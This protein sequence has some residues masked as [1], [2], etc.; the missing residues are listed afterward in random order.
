MVQIVADGNCRK[1][2]VDGDPGREKGA[3][4]EN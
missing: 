2:G 1:E 4:R 3:G